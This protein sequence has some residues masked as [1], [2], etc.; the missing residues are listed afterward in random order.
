M[1][2]DGEEFGELPAELEVEPDA[3]TVVAPWRN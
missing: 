1:Q 3:L 2:L